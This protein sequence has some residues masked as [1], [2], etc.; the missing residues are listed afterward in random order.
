MMSVTVLVLVG[1]L[2]HAIVPT[3]PR[4]ARGRRPLGR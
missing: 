1:V 3:P 4:R 2:L